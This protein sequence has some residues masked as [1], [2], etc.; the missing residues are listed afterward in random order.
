[1][2]L[3]V[4]LLPYFMAT[5]PHPFAGGAIRRSSAISV[6]LLAGGGA[7]RALDSHEMSGIAAGSSETGGTGEEAP[8]AASKNV[9]HVDEQLISEVIYYP[10]AELTNRPLAL[11]EVELGSLT[12]LG[13][14]GSGRVVLDLWV[15]ENG[16]VAKASVE[17]SDLPEP[18]LNAIVAA[19]QK[20]QFK[21]GELDGKAV[22]AIMKIEVIYDESGLPAP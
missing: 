20:L 14:A 3:L 4:L 21:P 22:G 15:N 10:S 17:S 18:V 5:D 9:V 8:G 7:K 6:M 1:M 16:D 13:D 12:F 19:F 11:T 2:H